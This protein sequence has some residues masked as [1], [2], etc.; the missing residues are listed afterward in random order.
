MNPFG[1]MPPFGINDAEQLRQARAYAA[2]LRDEWRRANASG[3]GPGGERQPG[4]LTRARRRTG[5]ALIG[6]GNRLL[7]AD[8]GS[9]RATTT[10][11]RAEPGR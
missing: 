3:S 8:P 7:A 2:M 4:A 11:P 9:P 1:F 6:L 10:A 5:G